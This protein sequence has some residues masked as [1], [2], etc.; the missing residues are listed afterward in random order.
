M[1]LLRASMIAVFDGGMTDAA[2]PVAETPANSNPANPI[3]IADFG[4]ARSP[5][6]AFGSV[7]PSRRHNDPPGRSVQ[8]ARASMRCVRV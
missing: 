6:L 8:V 4:I 1:L 2:W 3:A 5:P 7:T